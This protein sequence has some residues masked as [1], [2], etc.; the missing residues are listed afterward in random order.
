MAAHFSG[1]NP[2]TSA[3]RGATRPAERMR[4]VGLTRR[5]PPPERVLT[6]PEVTS[7]LRDRDALLSGETHGF[8]LELPTKSSTLLALHAHLVGA[9]RP[10]PK[11]PEN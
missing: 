8:N 2:S 9:L 6:D 10:S 11:C 7:H 3:S 5:A 1:S 4:G